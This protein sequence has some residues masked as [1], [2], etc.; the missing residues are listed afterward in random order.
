MALLSQWSLWGTTVM[1]LLYPLTGSVSTCCSQLTWLFPSH[2]WDVSVASSSRWCQQLSRWHVG[3]LVPP[4]FPTEL[5]EAAST[6]TIAIISNFGTDLL[7]D[8]CH[9]QE[10]YTLLSLLLFQRILGKIHE[11]RDDTV[12]CSCIDLRGTLN[13]MKHHGVIHVAVVGRWTFLW[14]R[15]LAFK[16]RLE[17]PTLVTREYWWLI[18]AVSTSIDWAE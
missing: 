14:T 8:S 15:K 6:P 16:S 18:R 13:R 17:N 4:T 10:V 11:P 12:N 2:F 5:D 7:C 1:L 9:A 3:R